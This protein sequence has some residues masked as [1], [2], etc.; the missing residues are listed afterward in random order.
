MAASNKRINRNQRAIH[1]SSENAFSVSHV[2]TFEDGGM[3]FWLHY[4]PITIYSCRI[5]TGDNGEFIGFPAR[6][7]EPKNRGESARWF[8]YAFAMMDEQTQIDIIN[9]V[10]DQ[11]GQAE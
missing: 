6:K 11:A 5:V 1:P 7:A 10:Y 8:N 3:T 4:G 9:M 2:H